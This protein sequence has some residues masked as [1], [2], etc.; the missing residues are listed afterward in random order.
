MEYEV[1]IEFIR[2]FWIEGIKAA[3]ENSA[4]EKAYKKLEVDPFEYLDDEES[5]A[6]A[7]EVIVK[8]D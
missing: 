4:I 3:D 2:S 7:H 8:K 1:K 6:E 5:K